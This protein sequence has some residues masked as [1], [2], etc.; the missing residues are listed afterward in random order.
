MSNVSSCQ[1]ASSRKGIKLLVE[2][3]VG[4][5][6][7]THCSSVHRQGKGIDKQKSNLFAHTKSAE[8]GEGPTEPIC[9]VNLSLNI[10]LASPRKIVGCSWA[11][12]WF[13]EMGG[14]RS[15]CSVFAPTAQFSKQ[16]ISLQPAIL[17]GT[18]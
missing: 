13:W 9:C 18:I 7:F 15:I 2:L 5:D 10:L 8:M 12:M 3:A 1:K 16:S 6:I 11:V 14:K 4:P 17:P